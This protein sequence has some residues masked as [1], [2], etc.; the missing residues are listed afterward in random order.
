MQEATFRLSETAISTLQHLAEAT[1]QSPDQIL[2]DAISLYS[3]AHSL[4]PQS[5]SST[6]PD[7]LIGL[8]IGS[9]DLATQSEEILQHDLT[10][11]GWT[12]KPKSR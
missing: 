10:P 3:E 1:G 8:F 6:E 11:Q 2:S 9:P 4:M 12:W 7:P 5:A